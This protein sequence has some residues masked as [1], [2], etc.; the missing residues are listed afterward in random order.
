MQTG[1]S[2]STGNGS[3]GRFPVGNHPISYALQDANGNVYAEE[4]KFT[5]TVIPKA[6]DLKL[7][8]PQD[9]TV[10]TVFNADFG[11]RWL[12]VTT[13]LAGAAALRL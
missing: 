7:T 8:C 1:C 4:C 13:Q 11:P 2:R 6:A 3:R 5:V 9:V 12:K 10:D